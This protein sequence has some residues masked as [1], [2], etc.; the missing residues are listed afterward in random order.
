MNE[1]EKERIELAMAKLK[2]NKTKRMELNFVLYAVK[3]GEII[4]YIGSGINGRENHC[5]S[6]CSHVYELNKAHFNNEKLTTV[7]L[8]RFINKSEA[9]DAEK[10]AIIKNRP[11][12]NKNF[13]PDVPGSGKGNFYK[14]WDIYFSKF[15]PDKY[16]AYSHLM[17]ELIK[18]FGVKNLTSKEGVSLTGLTSAKTNVPTRVQSFLRCKIGGQTHTKFNGVYDLFMSKKGYIKISEFPPTEHELKD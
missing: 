1:I 16:R 3:S 2:V 10:L 4:V 17:Q 6:G 11:I 7:V 8:K 18:F 13:N 12:Y 5:L 14:N 15:S 9:L